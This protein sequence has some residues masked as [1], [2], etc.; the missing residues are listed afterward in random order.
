ML[1]GYAHQ[2]AYAGRPVFR[3]TNRSTVGDG[4]VFRTVGKTIPF[5]KFRPLIS[6]GFFSPMWRGRHFH[7]GRGR[8]R[9]TADSIFGMADSELTLEPDWVAEVRVC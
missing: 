6:L 1:V 2:V 7:S 4:S 8:Y 9:V 3:W 5:P